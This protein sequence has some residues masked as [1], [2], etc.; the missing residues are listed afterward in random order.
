MCLFTHR[1]FFY[2]RWADQSRSIVKRSWS[3]SLSCWSLQSIRDVSLLSRCEIPKKF[4]CFLDA[5]PFCS[6]LL[7]IYQVP[8]SCIRRFTSDI[9]MIINDAVK[10]IFRNLVF[11]WL[12][13]NQYTKL[14]RQSFVTKSPHNLFLEYSLIFV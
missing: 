11:G 9:I 12:Y 5:Y 14:C 8:R 3:L 4:I 7:Y 6:L 13:N 10:K 1:I 2:Q